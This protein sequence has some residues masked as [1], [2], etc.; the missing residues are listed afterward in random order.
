MPVKV[1]KMEDQLGAVFKM[2]LDEHEIACNKAADEIEA[3]SKRLLKETLKFN[4]GTSAFKNA[5]VRSEKKVRKVGNKGCTLEVHLFVSEGSSKTTPHKIWHYVNRGR[6][7][8]RAKKTTRFR[9]TTPRTTPRRMS[10]EPQ[11][12]KGGWV[13][14]PKGKMYGKTPGRKWYAETAKRV[15]RRVTSRAKYNFLTF[16]KTRVDN[17]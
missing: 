1:N 14:I 12:P 3:E 13:T 10:V 2:L 6:G 9:S 16:N 7:N 11:H 5:Q 15:K 4:D 17:G 8:F